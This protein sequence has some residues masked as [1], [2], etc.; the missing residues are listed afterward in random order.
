MHAG[1]Y[2]SGRQQTTLT[3]DSI[4]FDEAYDGVSDPIPLKGMGL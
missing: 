3:R 1:P 2:R 4:S